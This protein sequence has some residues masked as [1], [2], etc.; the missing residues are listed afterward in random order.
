M[1][2]GIEGY[3]GIGIG[4]VFQVVPESVRFGWI[5][6]AVRWCWPYAYRRERE[7]DNGRLAS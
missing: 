6:S 3:S 2:N 1:I 7:P 4:N 5:R